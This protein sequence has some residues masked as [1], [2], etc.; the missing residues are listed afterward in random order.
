VKLQNERRGR[1]R[2]TM[3]KLGV[4]DMVRLPDEVKRLVRAGIYSIYAIRGDED[5]FMLTIGGGRHLVLNRSGDV[6]SK[7]PLSEVPITS[8]PVGQVVALADSSDD[9]LELKI[10]NI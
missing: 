3:I 7:H 5:A 4:G 10:N 9:S 6:L 8:V 1:K 2:K